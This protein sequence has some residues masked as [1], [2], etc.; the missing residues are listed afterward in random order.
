V[1]CHRAFDLCAANN[2]INQESKMAPGR[3]ESCHC[4]SGRKYKFCHLPIDEA[5]PELKY[6]A[7]QLVY[8]QNWKEAAQAHYAQKH[9]HWMA[10]ILNRS[11]LNA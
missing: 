2:D 5:P 6:E 10:N 4:G 8:I 11:S 7:A 3:N 1:P 9:Y